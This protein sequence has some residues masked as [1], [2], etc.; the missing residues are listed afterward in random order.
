M[1][2]TAYQHSEFADRKALMPDTTV[3]Y[4]LPLKLFV[5]QSHL[6]WTPLV[7]IH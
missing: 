1:S 6:T 5:M 7:V 3:P 4:R 2:C